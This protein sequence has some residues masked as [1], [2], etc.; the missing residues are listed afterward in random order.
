MSDSRREVIRYA[1][2]LLDYGKGRSDPELEELTL[3]QI[4]DLIIACVVAEE[5]KL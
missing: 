4:A 2:R 5:G 1:T 3:G